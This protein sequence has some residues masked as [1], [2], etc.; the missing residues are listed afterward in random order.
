MKP[1]EKS[2]INDRYDVAVKLLIL[3]SQKTK[4]GSANVKPGQNTGAFYL[5]IQTKGMANFFKYFGHES[6]IFMDSGYRVNRNAFP[7]TFISILDNFMKGRLVG[8]MISQFADEFTYA[9]CLSEF[10][11]GELKHVIPRASMSDFDTAEL[12]AFNKT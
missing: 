8:V 4:S 6:I 12:S 1:K 5:F 10:K 9:K 3:K 2:S 7:I 11:R